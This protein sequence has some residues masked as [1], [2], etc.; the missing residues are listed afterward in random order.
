[1]KKM[2]LFY[3]GIKLMGFYEKISILITL[4]DKFWPMVCLSK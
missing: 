2:T 3:V 4:I 1:M